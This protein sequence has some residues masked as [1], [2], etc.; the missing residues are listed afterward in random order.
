MAVSK[1][2]IN[3]L[4]QTAQSQESAISGA[5]SQLSNLRGHCDSL[6][7][8]WTGEAARTYQEAMNTFQDG[9]HQVVAKL[10]EMQ[11]TMVQTAN[12]FGNTNEAIIST[13]KSTTSHVGLG[14]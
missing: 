6:A 1:V 13:A 9:A 11:Q 12:M 5:D 7:S 10:R 4:K 2:T 8:A 14:I 3:D